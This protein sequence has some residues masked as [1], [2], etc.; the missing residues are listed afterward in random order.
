MINH[1]PRD[2]RTCESRTSADPARSQ[3][4]RCGSAGRARALS[5]KSRTARS[6]GPGNAMR[7]HVRVLM[8]PNNDDPPTFGS[9][10]GPGVG[11]APY[12]PVHFRG[13][14]G[15][16]RGRRVVVLAAPVPEAAVDEDG[17]LGGAEDQIRPPVQVEQ[18]SSVHAV[19]KSHRVK[20]VTQQKLWPCVA[21][22]VSL[23]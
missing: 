6:H 19:T 11:I 7:C 16:V 4:G 22:H 18:G 9:E 13:P 10:S 23:H 5:T 12:V 14:V 17:D 1:I 8:L 3:V 2:G 20:F 21:T 15:H